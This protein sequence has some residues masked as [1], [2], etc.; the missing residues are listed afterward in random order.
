MVARQESAACGAGS[1]VH[2][3]A[4]PRRFSPRL[5]S[6]GCRLAAGSWQLPARCYLIAHPEKT[7]SHRKQKPLKALLRAWDARHAAEGGR[8]H[9]T[10]HNNSCRRCAHLGDEQ[11]ALQASVRSQRAVDGKNLWKF[12]RTCSALGVAVHRLD[13]RNRQR[14]PAGAASR[15]SGAQRAH[16]CRCQGVDL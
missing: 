10:L 4:Q 11:S 6:A 8:Q 3:R 1:V 14:P 15:Q 12:P 13:G 2:F 5:C 9:A 7:D 16:L